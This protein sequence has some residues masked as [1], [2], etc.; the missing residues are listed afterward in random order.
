MVL[1]PRMTISEPAPG[2][3]ACD[4]TSTPG[5]LAANEFTMFDSF[6]F[7]MSSCFTELIDVASFSRTLVV[8]DPVTTTSPS[9]SGFLSRAKFFVTVPGVSTNVC[10]RGRYPTSF[11]VSVTVCPSARAP[12][13]TIV[14][15]PPLFVCAPALRRSTTTVAYASGS[16]VSLF[17]DPVMVAC[18]A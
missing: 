13:T 15:T 2:S 6:D 18:C 4:V 7:L 1:M 10:D 16:P 8:P 5:A 9:R 12:G 17:T 14:N 3:P 11:A